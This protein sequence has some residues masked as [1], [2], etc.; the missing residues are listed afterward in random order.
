MKLLLDTCTFLWIAS[1]SSELSKTATEAFLDRNNERYLSSASVWEIGIKFSLGRL[2]LPEKPD[3]FVPRIRESS[4]IASLDIEEE[5]ALQAG[6][7]PGLHA[8]P[9]DRML[10]AQA[11]VH[12]MTILTPD[13]QIERYAVRVLW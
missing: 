9:F 8:D 12:G 10:I 4:G 3:R 7:L 1:G 5:S 6:R 2:P 11:I 13:P